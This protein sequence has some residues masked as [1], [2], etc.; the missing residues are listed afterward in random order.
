MWRGQN[1]WRMLQNSVVAVRHM[2]NHAIVAVVAPIVMC[3]DAQIS[4][5]FMLLCLRKMAE[6][7]VECIAYGNLHI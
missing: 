5:H 3:F 7:F 1:M 4:L 2:K 6:I